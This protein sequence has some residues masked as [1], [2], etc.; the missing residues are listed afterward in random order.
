MKRLR[1][2]LLLLLIVI[3]VGLAF[4]LFENRE[5][6]YQG[7]SLTQW[8]EG[9]SDDVA[10]VDDTNRMARIAESRDAVRH[11]GTNAVPFLL[12]KLSARETPIERRL[13]KLAGSQSWIHFHFANRRPLAYQ[14][15]HILGEEARGA[16][17]ALAQLTRHRDREVRFFA[18]ESLQSLNLDTPALLPTLLQV[19][20]DPAPDIRSIAAQILSNLS[21]EQAEKAGVY[22]AF[23]ELKL[24]SAHPAA[25]NAPVAG[26]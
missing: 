2:I 4:Q 21:P 3:G 16:A 6:R 14:G 25:T 8:L 24:I 18:L 15:F 9:Y 19:I 12:K 11:I 1:L 7:R 5:P 13:K 22:Q 20:H 23:P 17:P 10:S 26:Q